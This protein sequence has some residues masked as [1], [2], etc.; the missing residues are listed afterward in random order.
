M[1]A[2]LLLDAG[3]WDNATLIPIV[4]EAGGEFSDLQGSLRTSTAAAL[5]SNTSLHE[6]IMRAI[7]PARQRGPNV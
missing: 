4:Q 6:Q 1:D 2:F 7:G 3:P 5:F